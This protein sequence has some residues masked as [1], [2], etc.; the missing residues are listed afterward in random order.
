LDMKEHGNRVFVLRAD[1]GHGWPVIGVYL[2]LGQQ[3]TFRSRNNR[4]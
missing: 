1:F 4:L 3:V 2:V